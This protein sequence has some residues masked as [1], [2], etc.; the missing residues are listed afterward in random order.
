MIIALSNILSS[1][2]HETDNYHGHVFFIV[3]RVP[4]FSSIKLK[5]GPKKQ[6]RKGT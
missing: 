2:Y 6:V 5:N 1:R 3:K 4:G